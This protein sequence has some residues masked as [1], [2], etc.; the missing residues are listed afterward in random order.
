MKD[1]VDKHGAG[2]EF[3][4]Y[5]VEVYN[6]SNR[7]HDYCGTLLKLFELY[8]AS[9][10][11]IKAADCLDRAAEVDAY[12]PG[13][14]RRLDMLRGKIDGN[15][16]NA[17]ASRFSSMLKLEERESDTPETPEGETTVLEDLMLQAEIFLQYAMRAKAAERLERIH[18]LFPREE[19]KN[20]KL[21]ELYLSAGFTAQYKDVPTLPPAT[22]PASAA[23]VPSTAAA[24]VPPLA[25]GGRAGSGL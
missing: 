25:A 2:I 11:F 4:E 8:Y 18:K 9:G 3:L 24:P 12:E 15:H 17:I 5:M 7:E 10:N 21:R 13:H 6:A 14:Q 19:E 22:K 20:E 23:P 16:F 1:I